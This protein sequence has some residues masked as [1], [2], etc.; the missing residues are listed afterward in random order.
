MLQY[1]AP[2]HEQYVPAALH[3]IAIAI[4]CSLTEKQTTKL[5][6]IISLTLALLSSLTPYSS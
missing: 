3:A 4:A 6:L 1:S 2:T 5:L